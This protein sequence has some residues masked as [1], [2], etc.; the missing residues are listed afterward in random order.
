MEPDQRSRIAKKRGG[1]TPHV[2]QL[3]PP[4]TRQHQLQLLSSTA[5]LH[6]D[7]TATLHTAAV[8]AG[9]NKVVSPAPP[10]GGAPGRNKATSSALTP[11]QDLHPPAS[12]PSIQEAS[13][14]STVAVAGE[15]ACVA[16]VSTPQAVGAKVT[17]VCSSPSGRWEQR[18]LLLGVVPVAHWSAVGRWEHRRRPMGAASATD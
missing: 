6:L 3:H 15:D 4:E 18:R 2:W 11:W 13:A 10:E 12:I 5:A 16:V 9:R 1:K 7:S 8:R 17:R 14:R